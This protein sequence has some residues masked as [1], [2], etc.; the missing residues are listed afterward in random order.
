MEGNIALLIQNFEEK[1]VN[2]NNERIIMKNRKQ[3]Y[4]LN[5]IYY[6]GRV[7]KKKNNWKT[8]RL[9]DTTEEKLQRFKD[10][11]LR[12]QRGCK[13]RGTSWSMGN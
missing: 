5:H 4:L 7:K 10:K 13:S 3:I 2:Q 8:N 11:S 9:K 6:N 12:R 1:K